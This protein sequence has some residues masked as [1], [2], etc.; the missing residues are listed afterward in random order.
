MN[1]KQ[2]QAFREV[3]LTGSVSEAARN[4]YRTQPAVSSMI[5]G[6]ED[7]VGFALF[8]RRRGRLHP[9]PEAHYL[10]EEANA[11]LG[12]LDR[13]ER[14]MR[15]IRDLER[16]TIRIVS[17]PGPAVFLLPD[18]ISRF[19]A[20][21][22]G[23]RA[24]LISRSSP[25]VQQLVSVQ[26]YD[27]GLADLGL[28]G[29]PDSALVSHE[30]VR[31]QCR[32][33]LRRDDP[34]AAK[35][36]VTAADLDGRPMAALYAEHPTSTQVRAGFAAMGAAFDMR[37]ETQY[38]IPLLTFVEQGLAR[39]IVDPLSVASYHLYRGGEEG[40]DGTDG[41]GAEGKDGTTAGTAAAAAPLVFRPF[42]PAVY[43][44]A[45]IMTPIHRP[46]SNLAH[47]FV[48]ALREEIRRIDAGAP[49]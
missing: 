27:V 41:R 45:S 25:Q 29:T 15:S 49:G 28:A 24:E 38:F 33:A 8:A 23:I 37:F 35:P 17:M 43:L 36:V 31:L 44:V 20:G 10:L 46:L 30:V 47:A 13:T 12:R 5:A 16:G 26:Q 9:V 3:M 19:V 32:C 34:L 14:T 21:R 18:L 40:A 6:L 39:A 2:L 11:I 4:L 7:D 22:G 48:A 42:T 1:L